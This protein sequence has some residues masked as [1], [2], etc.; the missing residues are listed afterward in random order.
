[1][2]IAVTLSRTD[3]SPHCFVYQTVTG[4]GY[5]V[6]KVWMPRRR[7]PNGPADYLNVTVETR[8]DRK[9]VQ[10]EIGL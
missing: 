3:D 4:P 6:V 9:P 2:K 1:M 10:Q 7:M 5:P 8:S